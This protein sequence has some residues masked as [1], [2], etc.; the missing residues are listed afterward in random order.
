MKR[1]SKA[2]VRPQYLIIFLILIFNSLNVA[3]IQAATVPV[4]FYY[5]A[6]PSGLTHIYLTGNIN[7]WAGN[8]STYELTDPDSDNVYTLTVDIDPSVI[9]QVEYKFIVD[10]T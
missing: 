5:K 6:P 8:D 9:S 2:F 3:L 10:G 7:S 1:I 4:T